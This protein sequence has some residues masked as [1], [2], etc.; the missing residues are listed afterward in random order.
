MPQRII[1]G[2][3][4]RRRGRRVLPFI[5]LQTFVAAVGVQAELRIKVARH[6]VALVD[7]LALAALCI[8][9]VARRTVPDGGRTVLRKQDSEREIEREVERN[10]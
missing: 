1:G 3:R 9:N 5:E 10:K 8:Q 6:T 7:V 2:R 4:R